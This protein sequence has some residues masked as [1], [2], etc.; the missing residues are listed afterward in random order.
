MSILLLLAHV[1][2]IVQV[3]LKNDYCVKGKLQTCSKE[4]M[5]LNCLGEMLY[6]RKEE[7]K[8]IELQ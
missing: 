2:K 7:I 4:G 3:Q 6:I 1:G 5:F 8:N